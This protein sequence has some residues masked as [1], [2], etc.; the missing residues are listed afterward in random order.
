MQQE[1]QKINV[2]KA[3]SPNDPL[4]KILKIFAKYFAVP[5]T[6]IFNDSFQSKTFP[7]VWKNYKVSAIPKSIPCTLADDLRPIALTSVLAEIQETFAVKWMYDDTTWKISDSQY[8]GLPR[9]S[10]VNALVNLLHNW[11][12]LMD[13]RHRVIKIVFLD[14]CKAFDLI[15]HNKL[16]ENM[17]SMGV[18]PALIKWFASYLNE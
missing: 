2:N 9:S 16:L 18:R 3:P 5:F 6:E 10:T 11:H 15:D 7:K 8:G 14:F 17:R 12:K 1:L 4:L 13:E